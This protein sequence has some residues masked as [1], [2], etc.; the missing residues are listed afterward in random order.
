MAISSDLAFD[1]VVAGGGPAGIGA[2]IG[3]ARMGARVAL[4]ER[5]P[6]LGGMGTAALVNNFCP[7]HFDG[8]RFIIG[9]VF[10]ELRQRLIDRKVIYT[11]KPLATTNPII[12]PYDPDVYAELVAALCR[13]AGVTLLLNTS[14]D[15]ARIDPQ[16]LDVIP[17]SDGRVLHAGVVVDATGDALIAARAGVPFT[18]GNAQTHA[19]MPLTYC[20]M[21][22]PIDL[23][24]A[25]REFPQAVLFDEI[26][27]ER[28]F[29]FSGWDKTVD[30][31]VKQA[32]DKGELSI[33]RDHIS[34]ILS[35]PSRPQFATV[36]FGRVTIA[37]PTD[38]QQLAA[39]EVEGRRQVE[40]GI[41]FFRA[42]M[43]GLGNVELVQ[44]ARQIG[45]RETRQ[46]VGQ[47]TL[48]ADD[49]L[50]CRQFDDVIAQ[51]CYP[52]DI[53]EPGKITTIMK[54]VPRGSHYDIPWRCLVPREGPA[55]LI[56]AGRTISATSEAMSSFR[57]SPSVMAIGEAAGVTA[58][59]A[60]QANCV[61]EDVRAADVQRR[62]IETGG[63]LS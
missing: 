52:V 17:L 42:Y 61:I 6:M 1:V 53:H 43:P 27:G 44:L 8:Q 35:V 46:I 4:V 59:L 2:A 34:A 15:L 7:A 14:I 56:V 33:P 30:A 9:G 26:V 48:T 19:V 60:A 55:N 12:E 36:N 40:D 32:R 31:W 16:Q 20:Y 13:D 3:A 62:L 57:V 10:G 63:I 18:F 41:R 5:Y 37:D 22:G 25:A 11:F 39:A 28:Y 50:S 58:A 29:Y 51:C 47:Y 45:V 38:P 54:H 21:I 24:T 23:V 49:V